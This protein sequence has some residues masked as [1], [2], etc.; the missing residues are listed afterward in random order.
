MVAMSH[1]HCS[2]VAVVAVLLVL[3]VGLSGVAN[4]GGFYIN[5]YDIAPRFSTHILVASNT[6]AC[7]AG[8]INPYVVAALTP[9][10]SDDIW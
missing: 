1:Q 10:V 2:Q 4:V 5:P 3:A 7:V 8:V 6:M 9:D